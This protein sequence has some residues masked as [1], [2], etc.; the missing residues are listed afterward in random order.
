VSLLYKISDGIITF[1]VKDTGIGIEKEEIPNLFAKFF[2]GKQAMKTTTDG[3]GL[4]LYL[5][6]KILQAHDGKIWLESEH[7][8]GTSV[9]FTLPVEK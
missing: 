5:A 6:S 4:G 8:K 2:R 3:T 7:G 1:E 9:F